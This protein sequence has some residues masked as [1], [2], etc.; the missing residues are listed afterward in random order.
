[1]TLVLSV[2]KGEM[3][4]I[5]G[6]ELRL[7]AG[8][9]VELSG[10]A[11]FLFGKQVMLPEQARTPARRLYLA[12]QTAYVGASDKRQSAVETVRRLVGACQQVSLPTAVGTTLERILQLTEADDCYPA[13]KLARLLIQYEDGVLDAQGLAEHGLEDQNRESME[14]AVA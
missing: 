14:R 5:N 1:M 7:L 4:V 11:R 8:T 13:L 2:R 12:I 10:P 6:V 3:L 9:K